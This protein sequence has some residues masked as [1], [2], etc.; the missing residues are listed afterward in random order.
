MMS[1]SED[2]NA[3]VTA[4]LT[5]TP[6]PDGQVKPGLD[7]QFWLDLPATWVKD[8]VA[9]RDTAAEEIRQLVTW[10]VP[11]YAAGTSLGLALSKTLFPLWVLIALAAPIVLLVATYWLALNVTRP[12]LDTMDE[13]G[14]DI[15][16]IIECHNRELRF[17]DRRLTWAM[18]LA[19]VASMS[20]ALALV[21]ASVKR[22]R[23]SYDFVAVHNVVNKGSVVTLRG[24]FPADSGVTLSV[25]ALSSKDSLMGTV[26]TTF[27]AAHSGE[28]QPELP[29]AESAAT[30]E[31]RAEWREPGGTMRSVM[32]TV[33]ART[34]GKTK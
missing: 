15:D 13:E 14:R 6:E 34:R 24:H 25:R 20:A 29:V 28:L 5:P 16:E 19:L 11:I 32:H 21:L 1:G 10:L 30:Y 3:D 31:V 12:K 2:E 26:E 18:L 4:P 27:V 22:E 33:P 8:A 23:K 9:K 17:K 7:D